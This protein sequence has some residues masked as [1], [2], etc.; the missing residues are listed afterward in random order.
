MEEATGRE[1]IES[2]TNAMI[3]IVDHYHHGC[4]Y[5]FLRATFSALASRLVFLKERERERE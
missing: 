2:T 1:T 3:L 5:L 4:V